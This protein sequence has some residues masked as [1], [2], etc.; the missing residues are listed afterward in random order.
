MP[1]VVDRTASIKYQTSNIKHQTSLVL[2]VFC[3]F[4][5]EPQINADKC[6]QRKQRRQ[7][8]MN[9]YACAGASAFISVY[10]RFA[11][12]SLMQPQNPLKSETSSEKNH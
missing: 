5:Y 9:T 10:L 2:M 4:R 6:R 12:I 7:M 3:G 8:Q 11:G 1:R